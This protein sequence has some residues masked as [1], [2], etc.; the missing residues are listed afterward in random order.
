MNI[1]C[2]ITACC[3]ECLSDRY[4]TISLCD[5]KN[6]SQ[7]ENSV[8]EHRIG[9]N[10]LLFYTSFLAFILKVMKFELWTTGKGPLIGM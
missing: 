8:I 7:K 6:K 10:H 4:K 1:F 2:L 9:N 3:P 5:S